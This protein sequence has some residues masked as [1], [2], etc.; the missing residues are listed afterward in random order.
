MNLGPT[1]SLLLAPVHVPPEAAN[2]PKRLSLHRS[3]EFRDFSRNSG[4]CFV[5][6][7]VPLPKVYLNLHSYIYIYISCYV[8]TIFYNKISYI[9]LCFMFFIFFFSTKRTCR[10]TVAH[11]LDLGKLGGPVGRAGAFEHEERP[12][13]RRGLPRKPMGFEAL[14]CR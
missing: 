8:I 12:G 11:P 13:I 9:I 7:M 6:Y 4:L 14:R 2:R 1:T 5:E 3:S 10:V